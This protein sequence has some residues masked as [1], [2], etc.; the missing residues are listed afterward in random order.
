MIKAK[1]VVVG[2]DAGAA[3]IPLKLPVTIGRSR[4]VTLTLPHP[5]VSRRHCE[6][7]ACE[8]RLKVRDLGS[9][10][11]T[12]V[13]NSRVD[14]AWLASGELLTIGNVTFRAV[15]GDEVAGGTSNQG[16][17]RL[18]ETVRAD[19]S[20]PDAP[21]PT[22]PPASSDADRG[23]DPPSPARPANS[24]AARVRRGRNVF[25]SAIQ[26]S[27]DD[28]FRESDL[29]DEGLGVDSGHFGDFDTEPKDPR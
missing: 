1:L 10:N 22:P 11:G 8:G 3:E 27:D 26:M 23:S 14:E 18:A 13:A 29:G 19:Q 5:L 20:D 25:D 6:I 16:T 7:F 17:V 9:R 12:Y 21:S 2:G 15:Y 24:D 4:D 28:L